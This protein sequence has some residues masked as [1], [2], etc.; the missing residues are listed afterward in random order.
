VPLAGGF[1]AFGQ[2]GFPVLLALVLMVTTM[3]L[4]TGGH[5][6]KSESFSRW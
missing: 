1:G 3:F 2:N 6:F 5:P 4:L